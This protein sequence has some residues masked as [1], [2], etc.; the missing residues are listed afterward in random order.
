VLICTA[1]TSLIAKINLIWPGIVDVNVNSV[2]R[3]VGSHTADQGPSMNVKINRISGSV[4]KEFV[5]G[6]LSFKWWH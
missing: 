3:S 2:V 1:Y 6:Q 5:L 4:Q